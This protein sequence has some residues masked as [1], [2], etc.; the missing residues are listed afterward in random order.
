MISSEPALP[1]RLHPAA[2]RAIALAT[3]VG[4]FASVQVA[5][6][7]IGFVSGILLVR[8]LEQSE[9]AYFTIANT[10]QGT[11]NVL[12]DIGISIGL[13][14]IGGRVWYDGHRF[15]QLVNTALR[16]RRRLGL[17]AMAVVTP[18]LFFML[19]KNGASYFY[20][21]LLIG[22]VLFGLALQLSIGVFGV[23]PRLRS[24]IGFIQ[25]IDLVSA[26]CRLLVLVALMYLFLNAGV[27]VLVG[28]VA[29]LLQYFL[30][31]K[32]CARVIDLDAPVNDDDDRAMRGFVKSQAANAAFYCF[33]GQITIFLI[34]FFSH[35]TSSVAEVGALGRLAMIFTILSSLLANIFVPAF[36]RCQ[37]ARKLRWQYAGIICGVA[38][39]SLAVL[40]GTVFFPTQLLFILGHK[41]AHLHRELLLMVAGAVLNALTATLWSLNSARAWISGSWLYI[42]LTVA[43]QIALIPSTDFSSVEGVLMFNLIS[44]AP[45]LLLNVILGW[46]GFSSMRV[47]AA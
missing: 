31:R 15:G 30:L 7:L 2:G 28:S 10:M 17:A 22:V 42:P 40:L 18:I 37:S 26:G 21:A 24:E 11:I 1:G 34:S 43:T 4:H 35:R 9:Y 3:T 38:G 19:V 16:M 8:R 6:Q 45:S 25:K 36:A 44:A 33:Q 39:F 12:A 20:T 32:H 23:V 13:V 14:S 5:V 29:L 46:R 47:A 41:Y 27:A